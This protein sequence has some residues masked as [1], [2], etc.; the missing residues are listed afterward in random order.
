MTEATD[1]LSNPRWWPEGRNSKARDIFATLLLHCGNDLKRELWLDIGCGNGGIARYLASQV[2]Q[3]VG[4]DPDPWKEW[5]TLCQENPNIVFYKGEYTD[6]EHLLGRG[7][8]DVVVCNQVYEHVDNPGALLHS[9][10]VVLKPG[11]ICYFAGPN[12]L[13]PVEPHISWPFV[14]WIPRKLAHGLM[15]R[16][17]SKRIERF[18]AFS[19]TYWRLTREFARIGFTYTVAIRERLVASL[20]RRSMTRAAGTVARLPSAIFFCLAW[21]SPGFVFVLKKRELAFPT[22]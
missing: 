17:G 21:C 2:Q 19:W 15:R 4:V 20:H 6:L 8:V 22:Q 14:H 11:G 12:L 13:W 16:M 1:F 3:V 9:I 18:D 5:A 7:S 10:E